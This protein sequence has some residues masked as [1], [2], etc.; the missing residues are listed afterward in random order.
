MCIRDRTYT[1]DANNRMLTQKKA[2]NGIDYLTK[3]G[4][5][6]NGN[7]TSRQRSSIGGPVGDNTNI[8]VSIGTMQS[9]PG[10]ESVAETFSY[11]S[12]NQ[13]VGYQNS[14][15]TNASYT[16]DATGMRASK[17]VNG[18]EK[19]FYYNGMYILNEGDGAEITATNFIGLTGIEGR[20][21]GANEIA[22]FMKDAHGDVRGVTDSSGTVIENYSYDIWG[23][24]TQES[25][26]SFDN[27]FHYTGEYTD[28][29]SGL[30]YLRARYYD[31]SMCRFTQEDPATN[32]QNWYAYAGN[33]PIMF[34]NPS[35]EDAILITNQN[36]VGIEGVGLS[37]RHI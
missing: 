37:L 2:E 17:T 29:E 25:S 19:K 31:P 8:E 26:G 5:D 3:M 15:G 35:G 24:E 28:E 22:Y 23:N 18:V 1:Y 11:N 34:V 6:K 13:M 32:G 21:N 33:N 7:M 36:A 4:Y 12:L 10:S 14:N 30:T 27:P 9:N 16:Y 20:K